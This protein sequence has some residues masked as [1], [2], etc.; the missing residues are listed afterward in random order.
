MDFASVSHFCSSRVT[1]SIHPS[2]EFQVPIQLS[3]ARMPSQPNRSCLVAA[4]AAIS[5]DW[6]GKWAMNQMLINVSCN[7]ITV[8]GA[9]MGIGN[10]HR[11][12]RSAAIPF[13]PAFHL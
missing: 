9:C 10:C 12:V 3:R 6:L 1:D 11:D 4:E 5:E 8:T 2:R 7:Q 13:Q